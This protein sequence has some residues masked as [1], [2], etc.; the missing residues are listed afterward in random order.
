M[1]KNI[2][3]M[4]VAV[5]AFL[6]LGQITTASAQTL[7]AIREQQEQ[8]Q[9]EID[10]LQKEVNTVLEEVSVLSTELAELDVEIEEKLEEIGQTE[11]EVA[12][13]EEIVEARMEQAKQRLQSLQLNESTQNIVLTILESESLSDLFNRALVIMRLTDAGN[14]QLELAEE[15]VQVLVALQEELETAQQELEER[16]EL[17]AS[18]K[19]VFDGK[20]SELQALIRDNQSQLTELIEREAVEEARIEEARRVAREEAAR[21]AAQKEEEERAARAA[22]RAEAEQ[23]TEVSVSS[24]INSSAQAA[25]QNSSNSSSSNSSSSNN[26]S[27]NVNS[28]SNSNSSTAPAPAPAEPEKSSGRTLRVQATGYSTKQPNLSTHTATGIDL[29]INPRVIAVDPSVIPLGSM[30]EVE[31]MG[32]Y[33]AGDT[34]GAIRGNIIDIHFQTVG[35]ALS[36]GRRSVTIRV[37]D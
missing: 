25:E 29:R 28:N 30:V 26:S 27:S 4:V 17:A 22:A 11:S 9:D 34:G 1:K 32:V 3:G 10:S 2:V 37:L 12:A 36:W 6:S 5:L 19:E 33:I 24:S 20:V 31:G 21:A 16:R 35:E 23:Q 15:E 7:E 14:Q 18:Q 8:T 13:Q